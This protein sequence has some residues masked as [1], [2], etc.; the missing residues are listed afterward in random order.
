[1]VFHYRNADESGW[2]NAEGTP[3]AQAAQHFWNEMQQMVAA[4]D[5]NLIEDGWEV[6][7]PRDP[8]CLKIEI[9][10]NS[11]GYDPVAST[12]GAVLT[13][14][15]SLI[16]Q[17]MGFQKWWVSSNTLR[18]R[19]PGDENS[20]EVM[21]MWMNTRGN[22]DWERIEQDPVSLKWYWWRI[23]E[24]YDGDDPDERWIKIP[25]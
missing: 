22:Y 17:A 9:V 16:S 21:N 4:L 24:D 6:V 25:I 15:G 13:L 8:S 12:L 19:K 23:R 7:A 5:R 2:L 14:G 18:W 1:M 11:K 10:R 3:A 20:E